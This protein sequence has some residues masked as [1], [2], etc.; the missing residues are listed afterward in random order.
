[1]NDTDN[2]DIIDTNWIDEF[3]KEEK[4][5]LNYYNESI[6]YLNVCYIYVNIGSEISI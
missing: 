4:E 6:T 5:Y 2:L 1:M 3:E